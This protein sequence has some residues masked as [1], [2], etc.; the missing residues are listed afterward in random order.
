MLSGRSHIIFHSSGVVIGCL[1][2]DGRVD[3]EKNKRLIDVA[4]PLRYSRYFPL[5]LAWRFIVPSI[6][7]STYCR[8]RVY[9][10]IW[11]VTV[12]LH[13]PGG[14]SYPDFRGRRLC[15]LVLI[16]SATLW[17]REGMS[18]AKWWRSRRVVCRLW[19]VEACQRAISVSLFS[20]PE[21]GRYME[22]VGDGKLSTH[23]SR[24]CKQRN[25]LPER[26]GVY[27]RR[28]E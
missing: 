24:L 10:S 28:E 25:D 7:Q 21:S 6:W 1:T 18:F 8:R 27:G 20:T 15:A 3:M 17:W 5:P 12:G 23:S 19:L 22:V 11:Y 2:K 16:R 4:R 26:R 13:H 14:W 9:S